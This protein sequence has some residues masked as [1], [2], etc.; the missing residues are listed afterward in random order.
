[1]VERCRQDTTKQPKDEPCRFCGNICTSWKKLTVHLAKHMEQISMPILTLVEQRVLNADSVISPVV[2]LPESRKLCVAQSQPPIDSNPSRYYPNSTYAPGIDPGFFPLQEIPSMVTSQNMHTYPPPQLSPYKA[3]RPVQAGG[4]SNCSAG[5]SVHYPNQTYPG[6]QAPAKPRNGYANDLVIPSMGYPTGTMQ[7]NVSQYSGNSINA[8]H[9]P[10]AT[11][12]DSPIDTTTFPP[13]YTDESQNLTNHM[14][15][16][17]YDA[18]NGMQYPQSNPHPPVP[19]TN[20]QQ[21]TYYYHQ[22]Q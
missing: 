7:N 10:Y 8:A 19:H 12:T 22:N 2:E 1:M 14:P 18:T 5:G 21:Q 15:V 3:P 11:Y 9:Q 6:L 13:Y 20:T 16:L 17:S 4:Y